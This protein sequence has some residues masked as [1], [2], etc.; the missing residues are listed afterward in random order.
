MPRAIRLVIVPA[1]L[2]LALA[3][4]LAGA[5]AAGSSGVSH[6]ADAPPVYLHT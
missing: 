3:G 6:R 5:V 2:A 4:A 1:V